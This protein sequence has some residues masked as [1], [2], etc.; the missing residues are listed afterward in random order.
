[1]TENQ[2]TFETEKEVSGCPYC[3]EAAMDIF[4]NKDCEKAFH[5]EEKQRLLAIKLIGQVRALTWKQPFAE[6]MLHGK[7]ETRTWKT[8]YRGEV[9][10]CAGVQTYT[11]KE[12]SKMVT[13][14]VWE[15]NFHLFDNIARGGQLY[16]GKAIAIATLIDCRPMQPDDAQKCFIDYNPKLWCHIYENVIQIQPIDWKGSQGWKEV[17]ADI[18][19][20]I[21]LL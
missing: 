8:D 16:C 2:T 20:R 13:A 10:I 11:G 5:H 15:N 3:G 19:A 6:L 7:I 17:P 18:K 14:E 21:K 9:L 1:M 4:C 12:L